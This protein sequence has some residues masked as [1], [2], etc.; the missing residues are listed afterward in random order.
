MERQGE[1]E[2]ERKK[3]L[4][5]T[6]SVFLRERLLLFPLVL[7]AL[8]VWISSAVK[9][10]GFEVTHNLINRCGQQGPFKH[11]LWT[12]A[13]FA[14]RQIHTP[15]FPFP[16]APSNTWFG[17]YCA[18]AVSDKTCF[19]STLTHSAVNSKNENREKYPGPLWAVRARHSVVTVSHKQAHGQ[20][21]TA[22]N[23]NWADRVFQ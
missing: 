20:A 4:K 21:K 9:Q 16:S 19:L 13:A 6:S 1:G 23:L 7:S 5:N 14:D 8:F 3:L 2:I 18:T 22:I 15:R 11:N 12:L 10:E 17:S